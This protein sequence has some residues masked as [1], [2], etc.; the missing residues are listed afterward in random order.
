MVEVHFEGR[1]IMPDLKNLLE[2]DS[3]S[4]QEAIQKVIDG[5]FTA[6][7]GSPSTN[8]K[9]FLFG[10]DFDVDVNDDMTYIL[11]LGHG[12]TMGGPF[13]DV[14]DLE[15]K[16]VEGSRDVIIPFYKDD[17][18][19]RVVRFI[20]FVKGRITQNLSWNADASEMRI[21]FQITHTGTN[22]T[23][24]LTVNKDDYCL[25]SAEIP[26]DGWKTAW[27]KYDYNNSIDLIR[28][29]FE[30]ILALANPVYDAE[31]EDF[32]KFNTMP[33]APMKPPRAPDVVS[34]WGP[35]GIDGG[36]GVHAEL[37]YQSMSML[38]ARLE[39]LEVTHGNTKR[40]GNV[41]VNSVSEIY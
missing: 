22:K 17:I 26:L 3:D 14:E 18:E 8:I 24:S 31:L 36:V 6:E 4:F 7:I 16:I 2:Q 38:H 11:N 29:V 10:I 34:R 27:H 5:S 21:E 25:E 30:S 32:E 41:C 37:L 23:F 12:H 9:F 28:H 19:Y 39:A 1:Q 33:G 35:Q 20:K 13:K 15:H 40:M